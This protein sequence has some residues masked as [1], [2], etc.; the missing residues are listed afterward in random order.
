MIDQNPAVKSA[1]EDIIN[2]ILKELPSNAAIE[3][4]L[5]SE[6]RAYVLED[7]NLPITLRPMTFE[8]EKNLISAKKDQDPMNLILQ[9][10]VS[11]I[12]ISDLLHIDKLYLIMKLRE[13]SYGD[14]YS[15]LLICPKCKAENP[16]IIRLSELNVNP[17]P[18]DF[19]D[20]VTV[21]LPKIKKK[22]KIRYPR[23]RDEKYMSTSELML[24]NIWRFVEE[25]DG[26]TDKSI[27]AP[28]VNRLPLVDIK[29]I[30]KHLTLEYGV[31][32]NVK[33]QCGSCKEVSVLDLPIN[34]NFFSVN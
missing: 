14:D 18:D 1:K 20:P 22:I 2:E 19:S 29:T 24:D 30:L 13:I 21:E 25:I 34:V 6:N 10:C 7:P 33:L 32:T 9:K 8:D 26:H 3:V 4:E 27:I 31:D 17:V 16:S 12:K 15:V 5:P 11:N 23:V 28:V